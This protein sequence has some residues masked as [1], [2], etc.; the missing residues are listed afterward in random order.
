MRAMRRAATE[1]EALLRALRTPIAPA[2]A[3]LGLTPISIE[4]VM[5]A[6]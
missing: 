3:L 4:K 2:F 5:N 6:M 1:R